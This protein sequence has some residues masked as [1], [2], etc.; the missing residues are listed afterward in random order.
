MLPDHYNDVVDERSCERLCGFPLCDNAVI[1]K[2]PAK[3]FTINTRQNKVFDISE[4][5]VG[6]SKRFRNQN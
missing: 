3:K 1:D 6:E 5:K 2:A 4:R